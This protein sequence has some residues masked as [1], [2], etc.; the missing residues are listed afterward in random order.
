V[1]T[2]ELTGALRTVL[3]TEFKILVGAEALSPLHALNTRIEKSTI[4]VETVLCFI[5]QYLQ[6]SLSIVVELYP[7]KMTGK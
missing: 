7:G 6:V 3:I 5:M 2:G 1:L 4:V